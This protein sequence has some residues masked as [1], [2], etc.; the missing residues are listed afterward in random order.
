MKR[1]IFIF[2]VISLMASCSKLPFVDRYYVYNDDDGCAFVFYNDGSVDIYEFFWREHIRG[3]YICN[4][5]QVS[6]TITELDSGTRPEIRYY[7]EAPS[8]YPDSLWF[9]SQS[10][11]LYRYN[12]S[13]IRDTIPLTT[14]NWLDFMLFRIGL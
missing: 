14:S 10:D 3:T 1:F 2:S 8:A 13:Y 4:F 7:N 9:S 6:I 11:T 5:P 12:P